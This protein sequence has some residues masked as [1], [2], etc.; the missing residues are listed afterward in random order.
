MRL[1][2]VI[3][4]TVASFGIGG[5][6]GPV[7]HNHD[8]HHHDDCCITADHEICPALTFLLNFS[9]E[10]ALAPVTPPVQ[11]LASDLELFTEVGPVSRRPE[12]PTCRAPPFS[13]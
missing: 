1:Q 4:L 13:S 5:T 8:F 3:F 7:F 10:A 11:L 6:V 12:S 9:G 2:F